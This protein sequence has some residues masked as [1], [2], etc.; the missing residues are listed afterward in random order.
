MIQPVRAVDAESES[1]RQVTAGTVGGF[2]GRSIDVLRAAVAMLTRLPL[3]GAPV[4]GTGVRAFAIVGALLG[5]ATFVPLLAFGTAIPIGAAIL[6]VATMAILSGG[7]HLDGLADTV[8]ALAA[9]GPDAAERARRDPAV[10]PA[11]ATAL[12]L[13]LGLNVATLADLLTNRGAVFAGLACVVAGSVS[14]LVPTV[15]ARLARSRVVEGGLG[16]WF[17]R[18]TSTRDV[19]IVVVTCLVIALASSTVAGG[20]ELIAAG[21]IGGVG[22]IGLGVV[23]VR[24]RPQLDGDLLGAS[25]EIAFAMTLVATAVVAA[26]PLV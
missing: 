26:W 1:A 22:A 14:R 3:P 2:V 24:L 18:G 19:A 9:V 13:V 15:L 25:V 17:V 5:L 23:L 10:G 8:D 16:A 21:I 7:L 20:V 11:G 6:A 12:I 4:V